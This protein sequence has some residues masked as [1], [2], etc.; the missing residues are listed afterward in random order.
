MCSFNGIEPRNIFIQKNIIKEFINLPLKYKINF[1]AKNRKF[2]LKN[3]LKI[4]L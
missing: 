4:F 3:I 1:N 2:I